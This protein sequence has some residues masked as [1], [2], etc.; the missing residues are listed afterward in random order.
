MSRARVKIW[1]DEEGWGVLT[2]D[3]VPGEIWAH[4]SHIKA[5]GYRGLT[6]GQEVDLDW[7]HPGQDGYNYR[8]RRITP[9]T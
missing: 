3:E 4:F 8:A 7:E 2:S 1:N 6:V 5:D 9:L